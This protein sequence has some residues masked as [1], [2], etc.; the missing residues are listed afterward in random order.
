MSITVYSIMIPYYSRFSI[1]YIPI[2]NESTSLISNLGNVMLDVCYILVQYSSVTMAQ[3][4]KKEA[5][6]WED[7]VKKNEKHLRKLESEKKR[8]QYEGELGVV[9]WNSVTTMQADWD[10]HT[11]LGQY[12]FP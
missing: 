8:E 3:F 5:E 2:L 12:L 4:N 11:R 9:L 7:K 1:V 10:T 6:E